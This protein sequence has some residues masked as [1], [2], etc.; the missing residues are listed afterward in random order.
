MLC[1][2]GSAPSSAGSSRSL[3]NDES[4][5]S[6]S[7]SEEGRDWHAPSSATAFESRTGSRAVADIVASGSPSP[8]SELDRPST[9]ASTAGATSAIQRINSESACRRSP[10]HINHRLPSRRTMRV[11]AATAASALPKVF[12]QA[13]TSMPALAANS[14]RT[15]HARNRW[16]GSPSRARAPSASSNFGTMLAPSPV[17]ALSGVRCRSSDTSSAGERLRLPTDRTGDSSRFSAT[18][19]RASGCTSCATG[20][21][22]RTSTSLRVAPRPWRSQQTTLPRSPRRNSERS[23]KPMH[24]PLSPRA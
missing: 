1:P 13:C 20:D 24:S 21:A 22:A 11:C 9:L 23:Y 5:A 16:L 10:R 3:P 18:R 19:A 17:T 15:S 7:P 2:T 4:P 6:K 12:E 14:A 8:T